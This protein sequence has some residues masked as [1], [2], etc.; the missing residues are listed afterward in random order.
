MEGSMSE[1]LRVL[2]L[3][4]DPAHAAQVTGMLGRLPGFT[5]TTR[6]AD[7][8]TGIGEL[9]DPDLAVVVLGSD[10]VQGLTVIEE[11]HRSAPSTQVLALSPED[12]PETIVRAM[13]AGADEFLSLPVTTSALLKVCIKIS[14]LRRVTSPSAAPRGEVWVAYGAKGG[15]GVTT[16][17]A[18]L[19]LAMRAA[20]RN[21]VCVDLDLYAGDLALFLNVT[22]LYT[23]RDVATNFKRLDSVFLQGTMMRHPSGV[24][25]LAAA[26]PKEGEL[27]LILSG[28]QTL[29]ILE[30]L[31]GMHEVTLVDTP[32]IP[33]EFSRAALTCAD[34]ILLVTELTIPAL[35]G[36]LRTLGWLR[37]EG[38]DTSATV[39]IVVNKQGGRGVD[40]PLADVSRMLKLPIR[41]MIPRDDAA[42]CAAINNGQPLDSVKGG[43]PVQQ[44]IA[45]LVNR[46]RGTATADGAPRR[47]SFFGL[48]SAGKSAEAPR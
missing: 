7:Y 22:P 37:D 41:T 28:E 12:N 8:Q 33:C 4:A 3:T 23:L 39:E 18:N 2:C 24:A 1:A 27:P 48:F 31:D 36:C 19:A 44:A 11:V 13:R 29:A 21:I 43:S 46:G 6:V 20:G 26:P 47:K 35:R 9:G 10:P 16:L 42:V 5:V 40:I 45:A 14:E 25:L 17:V 32:G 30:L 34:R 38:V 15:V